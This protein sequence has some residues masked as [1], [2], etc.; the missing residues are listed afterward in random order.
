[1]YLRATFTYTPE[2]DEH[3]PTVGG[4]LSFNAGDV[5]QVLERSDVNWW[6][7]SMNHA[8]AWYMMLNDE[9]V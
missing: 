9:I 3:L 2:N 1:M 7:V 5:L 6:Q 8:K 4:G